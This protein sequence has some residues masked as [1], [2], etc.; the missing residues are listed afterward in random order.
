MV[1][2]VLPPLLHPHC[3]QADKLHVNTRVRAAFLGGCR[4][5][6]LSIC[7]SP[8]KCHALCHVTKADF[9]RSLMEEWKT[10][11]LPPRVIV[12]FSVNPS[13]TWW[14]RVLS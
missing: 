10:P 5:V 13:T 7:H 14:H 2:A 6:V 11:P 9:S 8:R 12:L 1:T 3:E 4:K